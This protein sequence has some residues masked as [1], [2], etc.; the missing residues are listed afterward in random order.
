MVVRDTLP[1]PKETEG[2][3]AQSGGSYTEHGTT[4]KESNELRGNVLKGMYRH[5]RKIN[6]G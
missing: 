6:L 5:A 1:S 2:L 3:Q 4:L